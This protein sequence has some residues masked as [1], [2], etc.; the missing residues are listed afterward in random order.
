MTVIIFSVLGYMVRISG[1][2]N[3]IVIPDNLEPSKRIGWFERYM[4]QFLLGEILG[5]WTIFMVMHAMFLWCYYALG[6]PY[7]I[8]LKNEGDKNNE[9]PTKSSEGTCF[10]YCNIT[11]VLTKS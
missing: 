11:K 1:V 9:A 3:E 6:H 2:T 5:F 7:K 4:Q 10:V 8:V